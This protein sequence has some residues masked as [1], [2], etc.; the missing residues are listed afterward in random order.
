MLALSSAEIRRGAGFGIEDVN[1]LAKEFEEMKDKNLQVW[2]LSNMNVLGLVKRLK[3]VTKNA[4]KP[5][6]VVVDYLQ[7]IPH[8][9]EN[10]KSGIDDALLRLKDYQRETNATLIVISAFNRENYWQPASFSSFKESGAIE[11][12][13]D[14]MWALQNHGVDAGGNSDK[15]EIMKMSREKIRTIKFS[16]LKNRN[17]SAYD[18]FFRYYAAHDYFEPCEE[19]EEGRRRSY[20]H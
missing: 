17:G 7:I 18:C 2:E 13:A 11:Y 6:V 14:S 3:S 15:S 19:N 4:E 16:C 1:K 12:G 8:G 9:K 20:E 10:A 5:P